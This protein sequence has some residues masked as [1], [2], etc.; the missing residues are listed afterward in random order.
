MAKR[1]WK[2]IGIALLCAAVAFGVF[3]VVST[4]AEYNPAPA[5][6]LEVEGVGE[7]AIRPGDS[8]T[9]LTYN[10]GYSGLGKNQDFFMDGGDMVQPESAE[11]V[12]ENLAGIEDALKTYPADVYFLQE[13]DIN[14]KRTYHINEVDALYETAQGS[15][16][17]AYNFNS[18]Y[19]PYPIPT[20]G[21][22]ESGLVT[23]TDLNVVQAE[24]RSLPVPFQWPVRMFNLKRCLLMER[25]PVGE[26]QL[27]LVNLHLE[28]YDDGEGKKA[29]TEELMKILIDVYEQG[30]YVIAGGD[31]NQTFP[32]AAY[33]VLDDDYWMPGTLEEDMLPEGWQFAY[34]PSSPTCRLVN[35]P[36]S[37]DY[38][39]TQFYVIDGYILSPN[40]KLDAVQT[41]DL[42]FENSDHNPVQ[43][44]VTLE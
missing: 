35:E 13:V 21:K 42:G 20:I 39:T 8:L 36:F 41:I 19:V 18:L 9:L 31:F 28:A 40:V 32:G 44:N 10:V 1:V 33:P 15:M 12:R 22:V 25:I 26:D 30:H 23:I 4:I 38:E 16:A 7:K 5:E 2:T 17:F 11:I 14:S 34:D 43:L 24:R 29:Q 27:T 37:G 6:Q 3:L